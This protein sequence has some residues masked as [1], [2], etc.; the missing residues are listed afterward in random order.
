M[1]V[2]PLPRRA[3]GDAKAEP[4]PGRVGDVVAHPGKHL[5]RVQDRVPEEL[6]P[7]LQR[8]PI[9]RAADQL[10]QVD[11]GVEVVIGGADG[12]Q[13]GLEGQRLAVLLVGPGPALIDGHLGL[14]DQP[15]EV[16]H[17]RADHF[18]NVS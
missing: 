4:E 1:P 6:A 16:E 14:Q 9:Q 3:G 8:L 13:P 11:H 12:L 2:H 7:P 17:Q 15:V 18:D 5:L 10:L